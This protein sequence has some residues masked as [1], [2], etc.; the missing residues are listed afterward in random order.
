MDLS[1]EEI[2]YEEAHIHDNRAYQQ[3]IPVAIFGLLAFICVVLRPVCRRLSGTLLGLDDWLIIASMFCGIGLIITTCLTTTYGVGRHIIAVQP[4]DLVKF[5]KVNFASELLYAPTLALAKLSILALYARIFTTNN[6]SFAFAIYAVAV[7]IVLWFI[8]SY[9][10]IFLECRPIS[11]YWTSGC[12]LSFETS[13]ATS[14]LNIISDV[15]VVAL[16]SWHIWRLQMSTQQKV[17]VAAL[18]GLGALATAMSIARIAILSAESHQNSP[19][20][21]YIFVNVYVFTVC[22]PMIAIIC[23][24]L[25]ILQKPLRKSQ[26]SILS[27]SVLRSLLRSDREKSAVSDSRGTWP[28]VADDQGAAGREYDLEKASTGTTA[29]SPSRDKDMGD[30]ELDDMHLP[31]VERPVV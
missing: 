5:A 28:T 7:W 31:I 26:R 9:L 16:P 13:V 11:S 18:L 15:M 2:S 22:E 14:V 30:H 24:C 17:G 20:I 10:S 12:Q 6:R 21:T 3:N 25:P 1:P 29:R 27:L 4:E 8:G 23:A 19:D